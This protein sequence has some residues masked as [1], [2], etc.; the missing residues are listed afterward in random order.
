[1]T[2]ALTLNAAAH[3]APRPHRIGFIGF[4]GPGLEW[5]MISHFQRRLRELGWVEGATISTSY[6]WAGSDLEAYPRIVR[7][8]MSVEPDV[9][10]IPCGS[11]L[12]MVR[13]L[14]PEVPAVCRCM[15]L[16]DFGSEVETPA[17]PGRYTTGVV[18]FTPGA[19]GRRLQLLQDV[20]PRLTRVGVLYRTGSDWVPHLK[21]IER[22]AVD[23]GLT[24]HR[25]D[26]SVVSQL[27]FVLDG[28][29]ATRLHRHELF[30][31][32]AERRLPVLYD[33][34]MFPAA[35]DFGLMSFHADVPTFF[36]MVAER[37]DRILKGTKAG[38]I[39]IGTPETFAL[40]LNRRAARTLGLVFPDSMLQRAQHVAD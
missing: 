2:L 12:A 3:P 38:D 27:P 20:I 13:K 24:I 7:E 30:A 22:T 25:V 18:N 39:P 35:E 34:T 31:L 10:V 14:N 19:T 21:D 33:F 37:V 17:R 6:R 40:Q 15:D 28:D 16:R 36:H 32:A 8:L 26:W 4:E 9:V 23:R 5:R 11:P 29:G 1:M